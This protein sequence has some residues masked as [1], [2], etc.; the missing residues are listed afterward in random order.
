LA[1]NRYVFAEDAV[2]D[3]DVSVDAFAA[4]VNRNV[5]SLGDV[6]A[7]VSVAPGV[8]VPAVPAAPE[9]A[10]WRH[11]VTVMRRS[12]LSGRACAFGVGG[13]CGVEAGGVC[14][15]G[16]A[17]ACAVGAAGVGDVEGVCATI[18]TV[19]MPTRAAHTPD[20]ISSFML[21]PYKE[22]ATCN[23]ETTSQ[24][25]RALWSII[26]LVRSAN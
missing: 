20:R 6:S 2:V 19:A 5:V 12:E 21:P 4:F 10:A 16:V 7:F 17:C 15:E 18:A 13:A 1:T 22:A 23:G 14:G 11:P 26:D 9:G 25:G 24:I 3:G 8:L